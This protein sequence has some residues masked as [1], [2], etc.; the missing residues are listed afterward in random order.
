MMIAGQI[1]MMQ[2]GPDKLLALQ[3]LGR[4]ISKSPT[5]ATQQRIL[6]EADFRCRTRSRLAIE[7]GCQ[8]IGPLYSSR[9]SFLTQT[10]YVETAWKYKHFF[11]V[12]EL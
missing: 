2:G 9:S 12:E 8:S 3:L 4:T 11:A 10:S 6:W 7:I 5:A 1:D